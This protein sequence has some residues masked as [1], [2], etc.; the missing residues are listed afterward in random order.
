MQMSNHLKYEDLRSQRKISKWKL[1]TS[2]NISGSKLEV[3]CYDNI[4]RGFLTQSSRAKEHILKQ[5][6][7]ELRPKW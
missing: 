6:I 4:R 5:L 2:V 1:F 3:M 7:S